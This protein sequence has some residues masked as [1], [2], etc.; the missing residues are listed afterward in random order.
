MKTGFMTS[1]EQGEHEWMN[2]L[3]QGLIKPK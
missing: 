3:W 1:I 2:V